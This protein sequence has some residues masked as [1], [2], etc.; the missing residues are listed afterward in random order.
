[1]GLASANRNIH[2]FRRQ[3]RGANPRGRRHFLQDALAWLVARARSAN[4]TV[5]RCYQ[6]ACIELVGNET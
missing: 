5:D 4:W 3:T 1:M 2:H 6:K